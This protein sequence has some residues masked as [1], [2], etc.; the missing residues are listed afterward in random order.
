LANTC[1]DRHSAVQL[2]DIINK[3]HDDDR[4]A[5]SGPAERAHLAAF[6]ERANQVDDFDTG[7][8]DFRRSGLLSQQW[9]KTMDR[10]IF[11]RSNR[12]ALVD[13]ISRNVKH[14]SHDT[15]S[16]RH[17]YWATAIHNV[18]ASFKTFGSGHRDCANQLVPK[19]L[20]DFEC[21]IHG[22]ILNPVFNSQGVIDPRQSAREFHV[23]NWT[24]DLNDF[25]FAH[26][27]NL[28]SINAQSK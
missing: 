11:L 7:R 23:H 13:R 1:E 3:L 22:L 24:D 6:Q 18:K 15:I 27:K 19:M 17:V 12:S 14:P 16:D 10:I 5:D 9:R 26:V 20:L 28:I 8:E 4:L 2:C 25:A 21:Q